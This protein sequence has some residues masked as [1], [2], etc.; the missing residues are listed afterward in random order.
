MCY[1]FLRK[2]GGGILL[3]D[4]GD[5]DIYYLS[6]LVTFQLFVCGELPLR[7]TT[8]SAPVL[9][10]TRAALDTLRTAWSWTW[11]MTTRDFSLNWQPQSYPLVSWDSQHS[12][13]WSFKSKL[14]GKH[15]L[16]FDEGL[17]ATHLLYRIKGTKLPV[18]WC[19]LVERRG[20]L[21]CTFHKKTT[22]LFSEASFILGLLWSS[23]LLSLAPS[24]N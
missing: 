16:H 7:S 9:A 24:S 10:R 3:L 21:I 17:R 19:H 1:F 8:C 5:V 2:K 18:L 6:F 20:N 23:R 15:V 4:G 14:H 12:S 22:V 11:N 13:T